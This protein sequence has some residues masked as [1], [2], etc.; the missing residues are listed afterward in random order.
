[1]NFDKLYEKFKYKK[2]HGIICPLFFLKTNNSSQIGEFPDLKQLADFALTC[3]FS[4]VQLLPIF[5]TGP[6]SSPYSAR[7]CYALNPI[8]LSLKVLEGIDT[9]DPE[10]QKLYEKKDSLY[11]DYNAVHYLKL[12]ILR[13]YI[14]LNK[15]ILKNKPEFLEF[16]E[17]NTWLKAYS[18]FCAKKNCTETMP[19]Y[20][21]FD[22]DE[23][24]N[25]NPDEVFFHQILQFFCHIQLIEAKDYIEQLGLHLMGDIPI[26]LSP[27]STEVWTH[28]HLFDF[29]LTVGA[30][31]DQFSDVG[32]TW[33]F[34]LIRFVDKPQ[35][36]A[37]FWK[38]RI[39]HLSQ[40]FSMY[41]IDHM[42]GFFRLWAIPKGKK[43]KYGFFFP[44]DEAASIQNAHHLFDQIFKNTPM[45]PIAEDLGVIPDF[46]KKF[47]ADSHLVGTKVIRWERY[48]HQGGAMI[49]FN[50]YP[51]FS[52]TT[53]STHDTTFM[54]EEWNLDQTLSK[55]LCDLFQIPYTKVCNITIQDFILKKAHQ[56]ESLFIINMI[57]EYLYLSNDFKNKL[58]RVNDPSLLEARNWE[59]KMAI[60][61]E[62]LL[63]D[64]SFIHN[65]K[66]IL[67][68]T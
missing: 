36:C 30:A 51:H 47:I 58:Y 16:L 3:G 9:K 18:A 32:Q 24:L 22:I 17:K 59:V 62:S 52:M 14:D 12:S 66:T 35:A 46:V 37:D 5:D 48:W 53:L 45:V 7:S 13:K 57:Q 11:F 39:D 15:D 56:S 26:L 6:V 4:I 2:Q 40:Y 19:E 29:Q 38:K 44:T 41:R 60:P 42:V 31:P 49:P 68:P 67:T 8:Y 65:I 55:G 10:F 64:E 54:F 28:K 34:P 61:L 43:A 21:D 27:D 1:M 63:L 33:G 50:K 20:W 23:I 25:E